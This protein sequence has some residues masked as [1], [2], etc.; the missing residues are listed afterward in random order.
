MRL[1][2]TTTLSKKALK[3]QTAAETWAKVSFDRQIVAIAKVN[4]AH[5]IYSDDRGVKNFASEHKIKVVR[6]WE[7]PRPK[8]SQMTF[9]EL[10]NEGQKTESG[11][12]EGLERSSGRR[13]RFLEDE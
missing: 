13:I 8:G 4:G 2:K 5:T 7:L 6:T 1:K 12:T 9:E 3:R 10:E 11:I